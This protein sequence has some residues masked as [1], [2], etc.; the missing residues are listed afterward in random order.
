MKLDK[1]T[2]IRLRHQART[3]PVSAAYLLWGQ[4]WDACA[5][6]M[7]VDRSYTQAR[8]LEVDA[9]A[10]AVLRECGIS[11]EY[12]AGYET[13]PEYR[14]FSIG[15]QCVHRGNGTEWSQE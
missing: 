14:R 8:L 7:G 9:A 3:M 11:A 2:M 10:L 4:S 15:G 6:A 5:A 13:S 1:I 12:Q